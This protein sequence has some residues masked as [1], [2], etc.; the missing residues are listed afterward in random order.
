M[1]PNNTVTRTN[2]RDPYQYYD[3]MLYEPLIAKVRGGLD[4]RDPVLGMDVADWV[5]WYDLETRTFNLDKDNKLVRT[6][7]TPAYGRVPTEIAVAFDEEMR[8]YWAYSYLDTEG[9]ITEKRI[10]F[11]WYHPE[12]NSTVKLILDDVYSVKLLLDDRRLSHTLESDICLIY[13]RNSDRVVCVRYQRDL[14]QVEYP[15]FLLRTGESLVRVDI[16]TTNQLQF[17]IGRLQ[18]PYTWV[19]LLDTEGLPV[20]NHKGH[21]IWVVENYMSEAVSLRPALEDLTYQREINGGEFILIVD[22]SEEKELSLTLLQSYIVNSINIDKYLVK[23]DAESLYALKTDT[24]TRSES[25]ELFEVKGSGYSRLES[26]NKYALRSNTYTRTDI[27]VA[28]ARKEDV[29]T[30]TYSDENFA[31][32]SDTLT[33]TEADN[34]Y[35]LL[36][37]YDPSKTDLSVYLTK[38]DAAFIYA[39]QVDAITPSYLQ[40]NYVPTSILINNYYTKD[41]I[42]NLLAEKDIKFEP[43]KDNLIAN[44][45]CEYQDRTGWSLDFTYVSDL[46]PLS[47]YGAMKYGGASKRILLAQKI[48]LLLNTE[49]DFEVGYRYINKITPGVGLKVSFLC[50]DRDKNIIAGYMY[51]FEK[52]SVTKL[53]AP[54]KIGDTSM[55]VQSTDGW[56][57]LDPGVTGFGNIMFFNY[58]DNGGYMYANPKIPYTRNIAVGEYI[59]FKENENAIATAHIDKSIGSVGLSKPWDY[60]NPNTSDGSFPTGTIIA[61]SRPF[62][63]SD[64]FEFRCLDAVGTQFD[65]PDT[66]LFD[67]VKTF[68]FSFNDTGRYNDLTF[69]PGTTYIQPVIYPNHNYW[70]DKTEFG[71]DDANAPEA[72]AE[73]I[74]A[75]H[76]LYLRNRK[77]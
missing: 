30:R 11:N 35:L 38:E 75:I 40:E 17:E 64:E 32:K 14:F 46:S 15:L 57:S 13:V 4:I 33:T 54:L 39:K 72:T 8:F 49:Y 16:T 44:G 52:L 45:V 68:K 48:P 9:E 28:F 47:P 58:K 62:A 60:R 53:T 70:L 25:H 10:E 27:D 41:D 50:L 29:Y 21:P 43:L 69:P 31:L 55:R 36:T 63:G 37:N 66:N 5:L 34:R 12:L 22:R 56:L 67:S 74:I 24:Y 19:K 59:P 6:L 71:Y 42:K 76:K 23:T 18:K 26:D 2:V 73:D 3:K 65:S 77:A 61:R 51:S 7:G 20:Y 1:I